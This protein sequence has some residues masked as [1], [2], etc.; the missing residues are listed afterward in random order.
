MALLTTT[1][2]AAWTPICIA[3]SCDFSRTQQRDDG[4]IFASRR[5]VKDIARPR[6]ACASAIAHAFSILTDSDYGHRG[7]GL[8]SAGNLERCFN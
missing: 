7:H 6:V 4:L 8:R 3:F 2:A 1:A 5:Q